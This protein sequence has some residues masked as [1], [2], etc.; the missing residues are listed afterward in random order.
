MAIKAVLIGA[1]EIMVKLQGVAPAVQTKMRVF[2]AEQVLQLRDGVKS[3]ILS[4]FRTGEGPMYNA[5]QAQMEEQSGGRISG[6]VWIDGIAIPY[7]RIQEEGG[8][9]AHPGSDKFQAFLVGN[10][11]GFSGGLK[12]GSMVFTHKTKP[13]A[14]PIPEHPYMRFALGRQLAP[15][16][17]G[18]KAIVDEAMLQ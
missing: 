8:V 15:F 4:M 11:G 18:M 2:I 7:A 1:R 10:G 9:I 3:N 14:I 12:Q 5:V 16:N 13:H 6:V 17:S